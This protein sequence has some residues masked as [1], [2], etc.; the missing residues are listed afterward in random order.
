MFW[1][2]SRHPNTHI[3]T[4]ESD[5]FG[6]WKLM[7]VSTNYVYDGPRTYPGQRPLIV[8]V[9]SRKPVIRHEHE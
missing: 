5:E 9:L 6:Y 2:V 8:L 4:Y 3:A 1:Y 7:G